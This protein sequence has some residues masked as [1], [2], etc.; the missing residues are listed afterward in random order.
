MSFGIYIHFPY[1]RSK[2]PYCDFASYP[3]KTIDFALW[4]EKYADALTAYARRLPDKTVSSVFFG[5]GTPSLMPPE[6]IGS[7]IA[8]IKALWKC[9]D[10]TEISMEANPCSVDLDKLRAYRAAGITRLS[11]GVQALNDKDLKF[12]GR[13]HSVEQA[14]RA[15]SDAKQIFDDVSADLIYARPTQT[16]AQ[17]Q[18]ELDQ[19]LSLNLKHLS[20]YQLTLEE[21]TYF[22]KKGL[23]MPEDALCADLFT[24]TDRMT[25]QAGLPRYEVSNH[26]AKGHECRHNLLYWQRGEWIGI[27]PA[28]HGRFT[29]NGQFIAAAESR[30]PAEWL[31]HKGG[32][33][34]VLTPKEKAEE[35]I[36]MALRTE[37][38]LS[39]NDFKTVVGQDF[40]TFLDTDVLQ[41]YQMDGF[42]VCDKRGLRATAKGILILNAL[43]RSLINV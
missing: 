2:C 42:M 3:A 27:G 37:K 24:L 13:L 19:A 7:V 26:A 25:Y 18:S 6:L 38:G 12:L 34:I 41:D 16:Y 5:G 36:L 8:K 28:A 33:E 1:C 35:L 4:N 30:I 31:E 10:D 20:L 9:A 15:V 29:Q 40:E 23:E 22:Y 14:L 21:G 17:W 32:E 43:C 11:L 39:R